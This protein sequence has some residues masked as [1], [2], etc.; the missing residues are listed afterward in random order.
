MEPKNKCII[1]GL[2]VVGSFTWQFAV[3]PKCG[4][5]I[6]DCVVDSKDTIEI[7]YSPNID[8]QL[9]VMDASGTTRTSIF[10]DLNNPY[11][12]IVKNL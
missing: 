10:N 2:V 1:C 12:D 11:W 5:N 6:K 4:G 3:C 8:K 9:F 7:K